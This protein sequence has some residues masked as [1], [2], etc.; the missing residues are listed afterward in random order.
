MALS[1]IKKHPS[2]HKINREEANEEE[3]GIGF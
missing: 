3:S 2:D 1:G